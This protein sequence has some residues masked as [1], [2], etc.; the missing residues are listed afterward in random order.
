MNSTSPYGSPEYDNDVDETGADIVDL[1]AARAR[2]TPDDAPDT[3]PDDAPD[4]DSV[5]DPA[6]GADDAPDVDREGEVLEGQIVP[7]GTGPVGSDV[8]LVDGPDAQPRAGWSLAGLRDAKRAPLVPSWLKSQEE[9]ASNTAW[10]AR[11]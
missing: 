6:S 10:A 11:A 7:P 5:T 3:E 1:S 8:E 2:N 9:F 4:S